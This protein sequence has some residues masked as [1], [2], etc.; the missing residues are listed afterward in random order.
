VHIDERLGPASHVPGHRPPVPDRRV[1]MLD[2]D[3]PVARQVL[4]GDVADGVDAG[5]GRGEVLIDLDTVADR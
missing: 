1:V 3:P 5:R 2:P 4:G